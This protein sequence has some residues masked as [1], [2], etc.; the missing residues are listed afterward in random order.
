MQMFRR[1][2]LS[3]LAC[4]ADWAIVQDDDNNAG[5]IRVGALCAG[6]W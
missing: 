4:S 2:S 3:A 6:G 5:V 1:V